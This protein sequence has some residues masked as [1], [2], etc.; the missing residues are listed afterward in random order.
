MKKIIKESN[1]EEERIKPIRF[2]N[3][4]ENFNLIK[5]YII[6]ISAICISLIICFFYFSHKNHLYNMN[7]A[8]KINTSGELI[9][10]EVVELRKEFSTEAKH[11]LKI[12]VDSFFGYDQNNYESQIEKALWLGDDSIKEAYERFKNVEGWYDKV[13]Q[14]S[15]IQKILWR[16][17]PNEIEIKDIEKE[18]PWPFELKTLL[19]INLSG[20]KKF[21]DLLIRGNLIRVSRHYPKNPHGF[22]ITHFT[23]RLKAQEQD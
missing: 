5:Y 2:T 8:F 21:Y 1:K 19:E 6:G 3:V 10:M 9:P 15:I 18:E 22:L 7:H 4:I 17:D 12:F 20:N 14:N 13:V 23:Y 11:H 16:E